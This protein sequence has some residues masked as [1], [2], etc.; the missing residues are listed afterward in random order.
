MRSITISGACAVAV[1]V[2]CMT[3]ASVSYGSE[4]GLAHAQESPAAPFGPAPVESAIENPSP[5]VKEMT[6]LTGRG[7][8]AARASQAIGLQIEVAKTGLAAKVADALA[9]SYA[10]VWFDPAAAKFHIGVTSNASKRVAERIAAK[11]GF[12]ADVVVTSVRSTW[13]EL[14]AAQERLKEMLAE[15]LAAGEA[16][17]GIDPSRNAVSI[18]LSSSVSSRERP[19]LERS[20][21]AAGVNV[22]I[23]V[24]PPLLLRSQKDAKK[25]CESTFVSGKAYCEETIT[26]GVKMST[27]CTAGPMLIEGSE[28]YMVTSGHCFGEM[29]LA[30]GEV[31]EVVTSQ[32]VAGAQLEIGKEGEWYYEKERDMAIVKVNRAAKNFTEPMPNPVPALVAEWEKSP[33]TPHAVEGEEEAIGGQMV[34]HEGQTTGEKCGEVTALNVEDAGVEHLVEASA[35]A[36]LGDSGGPYFMRTLTGEILIEGIHASSNQCLEPF[37]AYF[38]PLRDLLGFPERGILKTFGKELLTTG[39]ELRT[40]ET[41]LSAEWLANGSAIATAL[42]SETSIEFLLEDNKTLVGKAAVLCNG[43]LSGTVGPGAEALIEKLLNLAKE[44][45][46]LLGLALLGTGAGSDCV[47][48]SGCAEGTAT[49]PIEVWAEKLS[50]PALLF[51]MENGTIAELLEGAGFVILCLVAGISAEDLCEASAAEF[52]AL[53]DPITGDAEIPAGQAGLPFGTCTMGG[54]ETG[55]I[56]TDAIASITLTSGE[57]LTVS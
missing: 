14:I 36:E 32:Y 33:K 40:A 12:A 43:I 16:T 50:W 53:N 45:I 21:V 6:V 19:E 22:S 46:V 7:I 57:L 9:D 2:L 51:K 31:K 25:N 48:V 10:G 29:S 54:A 15:P 20:A 41:T 42:A 26:S 5:L 37:L 8:S 4:E 56:E 52:T 11:V 3:P 34:C 55:V 49:S 35:C 47:T 27:G 39:N 23:D 13:D 1:A 24:S 28:T 17:T 38:E 30:H 18:A 44:E